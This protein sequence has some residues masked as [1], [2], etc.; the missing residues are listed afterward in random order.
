MHNMY[1]NISLKHHDIKMMQK[2]TIFSKEKDFFNEDKVLGK[3]L[4]KDKKEK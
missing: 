4:I 1:T 3:A 2:K